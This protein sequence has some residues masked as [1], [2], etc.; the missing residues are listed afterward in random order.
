MQSVNVE[1][2][3]FHEEQTFVTAKSATTGSTSVSG[4]PPST[5][6]LITVVGTYNDSECPSVSETYAIKT[7]AE[8]NT[9]P[10]M[11]LSNIFL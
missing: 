7:H 1:F 8:E 5:V 11:F 9:G 3:G 6:H 2:R 4:L 10:S